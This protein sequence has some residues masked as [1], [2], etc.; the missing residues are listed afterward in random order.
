MDG[1][2]LILRP[3]TSTEKA[4]VQAEKRK[5]QK[6][7][8]R[9]A[10]CLK[11]QDVDRTKECF[12]IDELPPEDA[13]TT[14]KLNKTR[15]PSIGD[16]FRMFITPALM[17]LLHDDFPDPI[18]LGRRGKDKMR[19]RQ[20][21]PTTAQLWETMAV[22][23]WILG[24]G[25]KPVEGRGESAPLKDAVDDAWDF[26]KTNCGVEPM[27]KEYIRRTI[28]TY[29]FG[30]KYSLLISENFTAILGKLGQYVAGDEKLYYFTGVSGNVRLVI[31]KP[32][33]LGLWMYELCVRVTIDG[34]EY[35]FL[36]HTFM[37]DSL[38]D[39]VTVSS[40]VQRWVEAMWSVGADL[41]PAG[42][43]PCPKT[44]LIADSYYMSSATRTYLTEKGQYFSLSCSKDRIALEVSR[45]HSD[46]QPDITGV[47]KTIWNSESKELVTYH[48]DTQKGVGKKY[49]ITYGAQRSTIKQKIKDNEYIIPGY[50]FYKNCF[51]ACD[52][53]NRRLHDRCWPHKRGG[54]NVTGELGAHHDFLMACVIQNTITAYCWARGQRPELQNFKTLLTELAIDLYAYA[55]DQATR[56]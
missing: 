14:F 39:S 21:T 2:N 6:D 44:F 20:F 11:W 29:H 24:R 9:I 23:I 40:V 13:W 35:P 32:G 36:M 30:L 16:V 53:F 55:I 7:D 34:K 18:T 45:I 50:S 42:T 48:H 51:E 25:Q 43:S 47:T 33:R 41:V 56:I 22:Y 15:P 26:F 37:H 17:Q 52:N 49:N 19:L 28:S 54:R 3:L 38:V 10:D 31:S 27:A 46:N 8:Q 4:I 1:F 12:L 5:K